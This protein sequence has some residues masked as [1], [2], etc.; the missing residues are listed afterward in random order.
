MQDTPSIKKGKMNIV[1]E[2]LLRHSACR[3][4]DRCAQRLQVQPSLII[5]AKILLHRFYMSSSFHLFEYHDAKG[6]WR[7]GQQQ[8]RSWIASEYG[9]SSLLVGNDIGTCWRSCEWND[10]CRPHSGTN[11]CGYVSCHPQDSKLW[12]TLWWLPTR[13]AHGIIL[14]TN[15]SNTTHGGSAAQCKSWS[16][17]VIMDDLRTTDDH[18]NWKRRKIKKFKVVENHPCLLFYCD[19]TTITKVAMHG[20]KLSDTN[21]S[22]CRLVSYIVI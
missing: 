6:S 16:D 13:F 15:Y 18:K 7:P 9:I 22:Y 4:L 10:P 8:W 2:T 19:R 21:P 17:L 5:T 20:G 1:K 12:Q 3:Y 14:V 11:D